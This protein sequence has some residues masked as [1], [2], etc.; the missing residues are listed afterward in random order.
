MDNFIFRRGIVRAI[1]VILLGF[2]ALLKS[3]IFAAP[4]AYLYGGKVGLFLWTAIAT[5]ILSIFLTI[6]I[7]WSVGENPFQVIKEE[8]LN[9]K[10]N[11]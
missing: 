1:L 7:L 4:F 2:P 9:I 11:W 5:V 8:W 3:I 6:G 10:R